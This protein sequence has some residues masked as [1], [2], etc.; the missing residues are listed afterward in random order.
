M[1]LV[2]DTQFKENYGAHDWNGE[3]ECPQYWKFKG[4]SSFKVLGVP[5][6]IDYQAVV[7]ALG[8]NY[9]NDYSEQYVLG[10]SVES[11]DYLSDFE[12][13]QLEYD[14]AILYREPS[15]D[16]ADVVKKQQVEA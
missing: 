6:N 11:D 16:Y 3:G 7:D 13:S 2:I 1:I 4:G 15:F 14:G 9:R 12:K 8:L 5:L 10:W